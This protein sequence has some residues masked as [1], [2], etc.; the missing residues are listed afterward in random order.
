MEE[1]RQRW[2][3]VERAVVGT[4]VLILCA[5]TPGSREVDTTTIKIDRRVIV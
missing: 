5:C 1:E 3:A 4:K 2:H